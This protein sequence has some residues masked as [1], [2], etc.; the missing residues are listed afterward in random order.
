MSEALY[1]KYRPQVFGDVVGQDNIV[2]TLQNAISNNKVSHAYLFSGPRGTGKTTMA[3]LLSKA[4]L[5]TAGHDSTASDAPAAASAAAENQ[6]SAPAPNPNPCGK[7]E[8]CAS[9]ASGDHPD[10]Y[11]LDAAS[12][13]GVENVREE[14]IGRV[15]FA[16]VRGAYKIY[17]IDE[18]HMLSTAAFNA[19]LKTLEEPPAHV[20]FVLCTTDPQKV[21]ETIL[22][23]C[24]R[25]DFKRIGQD[26]MVAKLGAVCVAEGA[27]FEGSALELVAHRARG[28]MRDALTALEQ[29]I[30]FCNNN[31]TLAAAQDMLGGMD[32][33]DIATFAQ[34]VGARDVPRAFSVV[35][36]LVEAGVDLSQ[37]ATDFAQYLRELYV[38]SAGVEVSVGSDAATCAQ[39]KEVLPLFGRDRLLH[40]LCVMGDVILQLKTSTNAR[41]VF[42]IAVVRLARPQT[43]LTLEALAERVEALEAGASA[44]VVGATKK[45]VQN[46]PA[47]T[48]QPVQTQQT[49]AQQAQVAPA[50]Q[51]PAQTQQTQQTPAQTQQTQPAQQNQ[52]PPAQEQQPLQPAQQ[53]PAQN[54]WAEMANNPALMQRTWKRIQGALKQISMPHAAFFV[55]VSAGYSPVQNCLEIR[56]PKESEFVFKQVQ[57]PTLKAEIA[58]AIEQ[59]LGMAAP[60]VVTQEGGAPQ[61]QPVAAP[62]PVPAQMPA[63]EPQPAPAQ[64]HAAPQQ[65]AQSA[66]Q[67][68]QEAAKEAPAPKP[69]PAP[70]TPAQNSQPA[71]V[72]PWEDDAYTTQDMWE[73]EES[74]Q[75]VSPAITS[76]SS[77]PE[78]EASAEKTSASETRTTP[79]QAPAC[80]VPNAPA[81]ETDWRE[82]V[83]RVFGVVPIEKIE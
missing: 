62:A 43:D 9:I 3:R 14:I 33:S 36:S 27:Q 52:Q 69:A 70:E 5:C 53:T 45:Q 80:E 75:S 6:T 34:A 15:Q 4:M 51:T 77:A 48:T 47:H 79:E 54:P 26:A 11:E 28:G 12:R 71:D 59:T 20:I 63:P 24:Q 1:R 65:Q 57:D 23:R 81:P 49:P 55:G 78:H 22:S 38:L 16:P 46:E 13:T 68:V 67:P 32:T 8:D 44:G 56:I 17:I 7:C 35:D 19:L 64:T 29:L 41:L 18:V 82:N 58:Q 39:M 10:V 73:Y 37:F 40:D 25:F 50:Q 31:I 74:M 76:A 83:T 30:S 42:E 66:P 60:F 21:P 2:N 61:A 72:P